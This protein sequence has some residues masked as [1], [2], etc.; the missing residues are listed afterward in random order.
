MKFPGEDCAINEEC[1]SGKCR[2]YSANETLCE[3]LPENEV[4]KENSDCDKSLYCHIDEGQ[5]SGKSNL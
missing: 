2:V 5:V 1:T 4:C 3:G